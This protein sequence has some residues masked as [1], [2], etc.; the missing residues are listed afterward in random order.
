MRTKAN[1]LS[2]NV[3]IYPKEKNL[4]A[5]TSELQKTIALIKQLSCFHIDCLRC[6]LSTVFELQNTL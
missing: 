1:L 2:S 4:L 3:K 6:I 5:L